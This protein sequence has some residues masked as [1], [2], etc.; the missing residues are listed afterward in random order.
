LKEI[1]EVSYIVLGRIGF[2]TDSNTA[3]HFLHEPVSQ[4]GINQWAD[5]TDQILWKRHNTS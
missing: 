2:Q 5:L 4:R 1:H 3:V